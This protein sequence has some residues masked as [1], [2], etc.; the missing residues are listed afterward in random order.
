MQEWCSCFHGNVSGSWQWRVRVLH[1]IPTPT[2]ASGLYFGK[3]GVPWLVVK[4][5]SG[6]QSALVREK[7]QHRGF[8][9]LL[10]PPGEESLYTFSEKVSHLP[11]VMWLER[12]KSRIRIQV[13]WFLC[14][15]IFFFFTRLFFWIHGFETME[16]FSNRFPSIS[17]VLGLGLAG[18][19]SESIT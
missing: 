18:P 9:G 3:G 4:V 1:S 16:R 2:P 12:D 6:K 15:S 5:P 8:S 19:C 13:S 14:L 17:R 10:E 7:W 11:R